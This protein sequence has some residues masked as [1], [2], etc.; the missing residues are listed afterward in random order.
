MVRRAVRTRLLVTIDG[1]APEILELGGVAMAAD[2]TGGLVY[3]RTDAGRTHVFAARFDG[4]RWAPPVRVDVGQPYNSAWPRIGAAN[5]GRLVV[6]WTQDGGDGLDGLWAAALPAGRSHFLAPTLVDFNVGEDLATYPSIAM[7]SGGAALM[8]YRVVRSFSGGG[9]PAG[10]VSGDVRLAR[11]DGSRWQRLGVPATRTRAPPLPAPTPDNAPR[12]ALD[13]AGN[14]VVAW[15]EPDDDFVSRIW[16]RRIFGTRLGVAQAASPV[17]AGGQLVRGGADQVALAETE[18]GRVVVAFRQLPDPRDRSAAALLYVNQMND[19]T[20]ENARSFTGPELV[21]PAGAATPALALGDDEDAVLA[22]P[23]AGTAALAYRP[24][25]GPFAARDL[26]DALDGPPPALTAGSDGRGVLAA[27]PGGG[28]GEVFVQELDGASVVESRSVF[29]PLGGAVR[30]LAVAG[31]GAGDALVAFAQGADGDRTIAA[32]VVDA[33]PSPFALTL[34]SWTREPRPTL[35]W[36]PARDA[37]GP[38]R[39][40]V[41]IDG[42]RVARTSARRLRLREGTLAQGSHRVE[43]IARDSAGQ[44]TAARPA[45]YELDRQAPLA[46]LSRKGRR[47]VVQIVDPGGRRAS[48]PGEERSSVQ[49]GDGGVSQF[50]TRRANH[51]YTRRGRFTVTVVAMD[52][53]GNRAVMRRSIAQR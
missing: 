8:T 15:Q 4:R 32:T 27:A 13:A 14:G 11:F 3:R 7:T 37:L 10:Y 21:G 2:G 23:R 36:D 19:S 45:F 33:A 42:R 46:R 22:L 39:Y 17:R 24:K 28:G 1:P 6:A 31:T 47:V 29:A 16:A 20:S 44:D 34:P 53:A 12:V 48:G 9:L 26:G 40:T 25:P 18:L 50:V 49:W 43:V 51:V 38:V 30:E 5:G 35:S 41:A 52:A